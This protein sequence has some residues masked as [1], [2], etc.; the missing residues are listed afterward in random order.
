MSKKKMKFIRMGEVVSFMNNKNKREY[1]GKYMGSGCEESL[2]LMFE[3]SKGDYVTVLQGDCIS[4]SGEVLA[5]DGYNGLLE[6]VK[7]YN[8]RTGRN[9]QLLDKLVLFGLPYVQVWQSQD[10]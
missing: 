1:K 5:C 4:M 9:V 6:Q 8:E 10:N 7:M 2:S 3:L